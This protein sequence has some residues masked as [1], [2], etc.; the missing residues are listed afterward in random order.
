MI[1]KKRGRVYIRCWIIV[2]VEICVFVHYFWEDVEDVEDEWAAQ[3]DGWN[4]ADSSCSAED[5]H[6]FCQLFRSL[7]LK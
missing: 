1:A 3:R 2:G 4:S 5:E 7:Y 6:A